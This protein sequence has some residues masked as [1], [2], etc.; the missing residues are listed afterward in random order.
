[1]CLVG[2]VRH[3]LHQGHY[4]VLEDVHWIGKFR[5]IGVAAQC[6]WQCEI[7]L[8]RSEALRTLFLNNCRC[9]VRFAIFPRSTLCCRYFFVLWLTFQI[10]DTYKVVV[11][12]R[13]WLVKHDDLLGD[14][15]V[16]FSF[17]LRSG[18]RR[19]L[20]NLVT[21]GALARFLL[22][23]HDLSIWFLSIFSAGH[24]LK[25][26]CGEVVTSFWDYAIVLIATVDLALAILLTRYELLFDV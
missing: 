18:S 19:R 3:L 26:L 6:F 14:L 23:L 8:I 11:L 2:P 13:W 1:M 7:I 15:P 17:C 4:F 12:I 22:R 9:I 24:H 5:L 21:K 16:Q 10:H 20:L 25:A